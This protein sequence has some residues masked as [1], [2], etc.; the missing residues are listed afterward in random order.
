M[1]PSNSRLGKR[2]QPISSPAM[3]LWVWRGRTKRERPAGERT[4]DGYRKLKTTTRRRER[5]NVFLPAALV[6]VDY[7]EPARLVYAVASTRPEQTVTIER[8]E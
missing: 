7:Q 5:P 4:L 6:E 8:K 1:R 3:S 2:W